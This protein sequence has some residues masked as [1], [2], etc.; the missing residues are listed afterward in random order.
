MKKS[1]LTKA[2]LMI[3]VLVISA[4]LA[5]C[6]TNSASSNQASPAASSAPSATAT[7]TPK[8]ET[9]VDAIQKKGTLVIATGNYYPF[10]YHD[11]KTNELVGYDIDLGN[12]IAKKLGVKVEWKEMQ[13]QSLIPTLQNHQA[14]MVIAAMYIT[15]QRKQVIDMSESYMKTGMS[16]V[17]RSDDA[18]INSLKDINGKT[19]GVKSG[20]T[21]EK[22]AQDLNANN[23]AKLTIKAYK[24]TTDYMT[25]LQLKRVDVAFNDYLNQLGYN[26][27]HP[28]AKLEIVGDPFV[29]ADLGIG[30]NKGQTELVN[31]V[32]SVIEDMQ[33]S[34]EADQLFSKW[35]K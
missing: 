25:D 27:Q 6:G 23:G 16:L 28:N 5:G 21:S 31:L 7:P 19:V 10:E 18:S 8:P 12:M 2:L 24:D 32:N 17:R 11:P 3:F 30:V 1:M 13:F 22:A 9:A 26:K 20:A 35:L 34:G 15:D 29:K 33:K 4:A 14:D